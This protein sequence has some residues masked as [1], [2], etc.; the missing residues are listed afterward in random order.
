MTGIT[1]REVPL[2]RQK[3][4]LHRAGKTDWDA[5]RLPVTRIQARPPA[6]MKVVGFR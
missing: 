5:I 6:V 4:A 3:E 2:L 1:Q